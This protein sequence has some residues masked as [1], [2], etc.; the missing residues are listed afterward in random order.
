MSRFFS[1]NFLKNMQLH[2]PSLLPILRLWVKGHQILS[3]RHRKWASTVFSLL[4]SLLQTTIFIIGCLE[5]FHALAFLPV[6]KPIIFFSFSSLLLIFI[7]WHLLL[8]SIVFTMQLNLSH[9]NQS[10]RT[11]IY[12]DEKPQEW[13]VDI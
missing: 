6:L 7:S 9:V 10:L 3:L 8:M 12:M 5:S 13:Y 1:Y 4:I 11:K 2:L